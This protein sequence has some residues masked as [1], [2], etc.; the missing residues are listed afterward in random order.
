MDSWSSLLAS[1]Q[2]DTIGKDCE[3]SGL[4]YRYKDKIQVTMM[5][6]V[7]DIIGVTEAGYKAHQLNA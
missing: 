6:M 3:N 1:V 2:I 4:G 5:G 7:D